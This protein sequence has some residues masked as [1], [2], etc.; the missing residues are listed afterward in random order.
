MLPPDVRTAVATAFQEHESLLDVRDG[1]T[2]DQAALGVRRVAVPAAV[3]PYLFVV[4]HDRPDA[5]SSLRELAWSRPDLLG[6]VFD[7]RWM[8]DRRC[9]HESGRAERRSSER[10]RAA[11]VRSWDKLGFLLAAPPEPSPPIPTADVRGRASLDGAARGT[12]P[13]VSAA[14]A[15]SRAPVRPGW[16][17]RRIVP[18]LLFLLA[19]GAGAAAV[20]FLSPLDRLADVY[21]TLSSVE[22]PVAPSPQPARSV[23][24]PL[25][26]PVKAPAR[27]TVVPPASDP[28]AHRAARQDPPEVVSTPIAP[29]RPAGGAGVPADQ[30]VTP[31]PAAVALSGKEVLGPVVGVKV[32]A[33][34]EPHRCFYVVERDAGVQWVVDSARVE[35]RPQ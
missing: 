21:R 34:V 11:T 15:V 19:A 28:G 14:H 27:P 22:T 5:F 16:D 31:S 2:A 25:S 32:D 13:L 10:R 23:A 33:T 24:P 29:S 1:V 12:E 3:P 7:R 35:L 17:H 9:K 30:C 8:G 26:P 18:G 6:V 20:V 4:R